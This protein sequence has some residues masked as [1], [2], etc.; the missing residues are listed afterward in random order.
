MATLHPYIRFLGSLPQF[1]IDN[2]QGTAVDMR[3]GAVVSKYTG[4]APHHLHCLAI[5]WPGQSPERPLL[6]SATKYVP[7][8][9]SEAIQL[10]AP[11]AELLDASRHIFAEAGEAH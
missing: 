9:V 10:G 11:R 4:N 1:E 7:L 8:Q 2:R 3:T 6:V 5:V